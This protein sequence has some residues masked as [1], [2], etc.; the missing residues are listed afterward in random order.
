M[1]TADQARG[2]G[3]SMTYGLK[4]RLRGLGSMFSPGLKFDG[5]AS[6]RLL[7]APH[8]L[9]TA[10]ATIAND[11][12]RGRLSLAG[13]VADIGT[14]SP[15]LLTP[16][17][18]A[19]QEELLSFAWLRHLHAADDAV[20]R[21]HA[22][23][24]IGDWIAIQG[25]G[26]PVAWKPEVMARRIIS[27]LSHSPLYLERA[28]PAYYQAVMKSFG[29]QLRYLSRHARDAED[30]LP[31]AT[32]YIA[33]AYATLC[34]SGLERLQSR[35]GRILG[36]E[37]GRQV[38]PDG[39]H[40]SRDP[41]AILELLLD[42]LPLRQTYLSRD[43]APPSEVIGAIDR[44]LPMV[45]FFRHGDGDFALFN[46]MGRTPTGAISSVL[47][48]DDTLGRHAEQAP[49]SGYQRLEAGTT[50]VLMDA[51]APPPT[52]VSGKAH[53]GC[54]SFELSSG[55]QRIITNCGTSPALRDEWRHAARLTA[56]HS[57]LTVENL[58]SARFLGA[59]RGQST[60][61]AP[62]V[63][64]PKSV[65]VTRGSLDTGTSI[66]A[67]H[68]GYRKLG[69]V[70][71]RRLFLSRDGQ[72]LEGRDKLTR[73][74]TLFS[75]TRAYAIRF[76]IHPSVEAQIDR[77]GRTVALT[78]PN[79]ER[80]KFSAISAT[81]RLEES[82]FL[83]DPKGARGTSQIVIAGQC[84]NEAVVSW[85]LE[86]DTGKSLRRIRNLKAGER[87]DAVMPDASGPL[88]EDRT[89]GD[90]TKPAPGATPQTE[91]ATA[92]PKPAASPPLGAAGRDRQDADAGRR[93]AIPP[94]DPPKSSGPP[95]RP[96]PKRTSGL[97]LRRPA[98]PPR[99][100][101]TRRPPVSRPPKP[102][103]RN[104]QGNDDGEKRSA[105]ERIVARARDTSRADGAKPERPPA[106]PAKPSE[107]GPRKPKDAGD[108][109][110]PRL[111]GFPN[112]RPGGDKNDS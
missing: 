104:E 23:A 78:L 58:S 5:R 102:P 11:V 2:F 36:Q 73:S 108:R 40:I 14:T 98:S 110:E 109:T 51:G 112:I 37:L 100:E 71:S 107:P 27:W 1:T 101:L 42:L 17:S 65:S 79:N 41:G 19:W 48:Y 43:I 63:G 91:P 64:G 69:I 61:G 49:H 34:I 47:A 26:H 60:L 82:V 75:R 44:M 52:S 50:L 12:Y 13:A 66:E 68:D 38:L 24:L 32:T 93:A 97:G 3:F 89:G 16:P 46:G 25:R 56:A 9:R 54:L 72:E 106:A 10:D 28:D 105:V 80:W 111:T 96:A 86:R 4:R 21:I 59:A 77:D 103:H 8:D 18:A 31:R 92:R 45:R 74:S 76:H 90:E 70:H 55:N 84:G 39:G 33:M 57:T 15:F 7:I 29:R 35:V 30:G 88:A 87:E 85:R 94:R 20:S 67:R 81:P 62:I 99:G 22:R 53:A 83:A 6:Q 95:S